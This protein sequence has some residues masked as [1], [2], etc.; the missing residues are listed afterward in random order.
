MKCIPLFVAMLVASSVFADGDIVIHVS[1]DGSDKT[2]DG[3]PVRPFATPCAARDALRRLRRASRD[4]CG[5]TVIFHD[6]DYE[7]SA[8]VVLTGEDGGSCEKPVVW[9][10]ERRGGVRLSGRNRVSWRQMAK[11]DPNAA[12]LPEKARKHVVTADVPGDDPIPGFKAFGCPVND[13]QRQATETSLTLFQGPQR[14]VSARWPNDDW[15]HMGREVGTN[16]FI[17]NGAEVRGRD[18]IFEFQAVDKLSMWRREPELWAHG[19]WSLKWADSKTRV[20]DADP[21]VGRIRVDNTDEFFG[22]RDGCEFYV[23]N[24]FCELDRPGEWALDRRLRRLYVW[25]FPAVGE[26]VR[27]TDVKCLVAAEGL[28]DFVIDGIVFECAMKDAV[29]FKNSSRVTVRASVVRHTGGWGIRFE[30]GERGIVDGCDLYDIGEGGIWVEGGDLER[31]TPARHLVK[32]CHI[33]H[34]GQ[35]ISNYRPGISLNGVGCRAGRNLVHHADHIGIQFKGNDHYIGYNILHALC[36]HNDD[37]GTIYGYICDLSQRGTV[38]EY[39]VVH[40]SG[41]RPVARNVYAIYLDAWTSGCVVRGNIVNRATVGIWMSGGQANVVVSNI[42]MN[43]ERAIWSGSVGKGEPGS[44]ATWSKGRDSFLL[45]KLVKNSETY[46]RPPWSRYPHLLSPLDLEDAEFAHCGLWNKIADNVIVSSGKLAIMNW[47]QVR[48]Y[49]EMGGNVA[50]DDDPGFVNYLGLDWRARTGS[51]LAAKLGGDTRFSKMGIYASAAR[52]SDP[53]KFSADVTRPKVM[54]GEFPDS[55]VRIDIT[56][57]GKLP[58][59]VKKMAGQTASCQIPFWGAGK[60]IVAAFGA[61]SEKWTEYEFSF[62]PACDGTVTL[63]L[64]GEHWNMTLYDDFRMEGAELADPDFSDG[65]SHWTKTFEAHDDPLFPGGNNRAYGVV[66]PLRLSNG[67]E[68]RPYS[69]SAMALASH[70]KSVRQGGVKVRRGRDV[71][72]RF[73]ARCFLP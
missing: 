15:A 44:K 7:L 32:N 63:W 56:W 23:F 34:F 37:A 58:D 9:K 59:G 71:R 4:W 46:S 19:N 24:A 67:R 51:S 16:K 8:P 41:D 25:P 47:A 52:A 61:A 2:G 65:G 21:G 11:D 49:T 18:G 28:S 3:S 30:G 27:L 68:V 64:M 13:A 73:R 70:D 62:V 17:A 48:E 43:C 38:I 57:D 33:H 5:A 50:F 35:R 6:G 45:S 60:R 10:S 42:V 14:L 66:G 29:V 39:N 22:Y 40:M 54:G 20:I 26:E 1:P 36:R 72:V 31:L 12:L 53:V 55:V 69:G